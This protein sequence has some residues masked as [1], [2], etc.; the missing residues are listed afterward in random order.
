MPL[1]F[2]YDANTKSAHLLN[3]Y[4][5]LH[6]KCFIWIISFNAL[7]DPIRL[8]ICVYLHFIFYCFIFKYSQY[9]VLY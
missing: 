2:F 5:R 1:E 4:Y 8:V 6:S 9:T 3:V 7:E